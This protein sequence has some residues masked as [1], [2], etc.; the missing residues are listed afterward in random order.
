MYVDPLWN[1]IFH[2]APALI[3][4]IILIRD[5]QANGEKIT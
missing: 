3:F 2:K 5:E 1:L 4:I